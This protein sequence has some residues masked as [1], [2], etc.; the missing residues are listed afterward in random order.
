MME[1]GHDLDRAA[2]AA[3]A[4]EFGGRIVLPSDPDYDQAR[5]VWNAIFDRFPA[6]IVQ[7][8]GVRDVVAALRFAREHELTIAV[9]GGGHSAAGFS[10][11]DGG[12]VLDLRPIQGV[13]VDSLRKTARVGAGAHLSQLDEATQAVG[14]ACPVGVI[15]HTGVA[16]LTLGGGMGRL[17]RRYGL[18][19][20]NLLGVEL[21]TADGR[22]VRADEN[23]N[24]ELFWGVR[25]AGANFGVV[26]SF[27]FRLH[28][29]GPAVV[30][31]VIAHPVERAHELAGQ[32]CELV[33]AAPDEL[34]MS[35]EF[36]VATEHPPFAP[37]MA[38]RPVV[39]IESTYCGPVERSDRYLRPLRAG[40]PVLDTVQPRS[41]LA[42]QTRK[43]V[44]LAWG[45]RFYMKNAFFPAITD[46]VVDL[47]VSRIC[48]APGHCSVG[49]MAQ[50]GALARVREDAMAFTGRSA[51]F[52]C[53]VETVWDEPTRDDAHIG[54]GRATMAA[55]KPFTSRGHY[56]NDVV[57]AGEDVVRGIYGDTKYQRL[58]ALKRAWD[59]DNVFRLN[60]NV[61]PRL[62]G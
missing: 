39:L 46:E 16:G 37:G 59:P 15:G 54:W 12:M 1:R 40:K 60:Q 22:L 45:H 42:V 13:A 55:L 24:S 52:W 4:D 36:R 18:T 38:G 50:G 53:G 6:C 11:C 2:L 33:A 35:L 9:R 20:D 47:C 21:V 57:E 41:Y 62:A 27:F 43:D 56:V 14:L 30:Q 3:F 61:N 26:T 58:V 5:V 31:G 8:G 51:A 29:V 10:T 25:G 7:C 32:F 49:F 48:D 19:I 17:Q 23:E 44:M 28:P 34:M